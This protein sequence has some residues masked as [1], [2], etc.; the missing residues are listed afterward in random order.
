MRCIYA[1]LDS[2][3]SAGVQMFLMVVSVRGENVA[4][5]KNWGW[6]VGYLRNV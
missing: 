6:V 4:M 3:L 5:L 2:F 1:W